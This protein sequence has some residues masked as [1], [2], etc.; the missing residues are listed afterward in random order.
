MLKV[1]Q[2]FYL[3]KATHSKSQRIQFIFVCDFIEN[4]E[5]T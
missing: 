2:T 1:N 4:Y 5:E 3:V